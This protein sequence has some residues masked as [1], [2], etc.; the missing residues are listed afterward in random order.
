MDI[1]T[2]KLPG[3]RRAEPCLFGP[4]ML[5]ENVTER[6]ERG[7][8]EYASD[9][10]QSG[11]AR[12]QGT[13]RRYTA[14]IP[15]L[16][17]ADT[18]RRQVQ[19]VLEQSAPPESIIVIDSGSDDGTAELAASLP[20]VR[21]MSVKR[22]TYDHGGT[23]DMAIRASDTPFVILLT[24][25]ALPTDAHWAAALLAPFGDERVAAVC[26]R[27]VARSDARAYEKAVRAFRYPDESSV[28]SAQD[29]PALGVRGYL[30]SDVCAAYRRTAYDAVDGFEHPIA[31]NE[32]ML[33]AADLLNAGYW[34]AYSAGARV[35]HS[36]NHTLKQEYLR[37]RLIG[38]FLVRYSDRFARTGETGEGLRLVRH[39][40]TALVRQGKPGQLLPFWLDCGARLLGNRAGK[41]R[42]RRKAKA[43]SESHG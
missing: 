8:A 27:Q 40:S 1:A 42:G 41:R 7:K 5:I 30:L 34:L 16:N 37:N 20:G 22:G 31:T 21:L 28:W 23:R 18:L 43:R 36:H 6:P 14:I 25:D 19:T 39:V 9:L 15:T 38:E 2:T 35:W 4:V 24:Q 26:G 33:I 17:A 3:C 11:C 32:D 12:G 10:K 13:S 29:L